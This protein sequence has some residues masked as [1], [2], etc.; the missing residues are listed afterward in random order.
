MT[1]HKLPTR[2]IFAPKSKRFGED[3]GGGGKLS[4]YKTAALRREAADDK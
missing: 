1:N 4:Q 2:S 3:K